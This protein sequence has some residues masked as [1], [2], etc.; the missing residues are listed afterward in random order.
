MKDS[1]REWVL[2]LQAV[3][4]TEELVKN[5][6]RKSNGC[7]GWSGDWVRDPTIYPI[8]KFRFDGVMVRVHPALV[9]GAVMMD[10]FINV[11]AK[12]CNTKH[13]INPTHYIYEKRNK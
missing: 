11:K 6:Q 9:I 12:Q 10:V 5:I 2:D 13:C 3:F 8:L 1:T 4:S 7:W